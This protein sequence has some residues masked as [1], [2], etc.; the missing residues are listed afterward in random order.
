MRYEGEGGVVINGGSWGAAGKR[1]VGMVF[2]AL[3][4][5]LFASTLLLDPAWA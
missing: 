4:A 2:F 1:R 3:L 5:A